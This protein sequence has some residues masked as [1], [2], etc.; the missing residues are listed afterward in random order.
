MAKRKKREERLKEILQAASVLFSKKGFD[1][2]S[3]MDLAEA[4]RIEK[5][6]LYHYVKSKDELLFLILRN[7]LETLIKGLEQKRT[8]KKIALLPVILTDQ[9]KLFFQHQ[10]EAFVYFRERR[11]LTGIYAQKIEAL[12][13]T[14]L[15]KLSELLREGLPS[16]V[17]QTPRH[18]AL[19]FLG[20]ISMLVERFSPREKDK[21]RLA[22]DWV[23]FFLSG[24]GDKKNSKL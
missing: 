16:T 24:K 9:V 17:L 23:D 5:P 20:L 12:E 7:F 21:E 3:V 18:L 1:R 15:Q 22:R 19:A 14:Y 4:L 2:T 13:E 8:E 6:T 11:F 10:K